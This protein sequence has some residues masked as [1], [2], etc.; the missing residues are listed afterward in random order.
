MVCVVCCD[1]PLALI[2]ESPYGASVARRVEWDKGIVFA[3]W[4]C[5]SCERVFRQGWIP[6]GWVSRIANYA[7][8]RIWC[9]LEESLRAAY[10]AR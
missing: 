8:P 1:A 2:A 7:C 10:D 6:G 5:T 3:V 9:E 4:R